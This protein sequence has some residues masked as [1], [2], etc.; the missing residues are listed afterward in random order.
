[1]KNVWPD[2]KPRQKPMAGLFKLFP[3]R[4]DFCY[5][6]TDQVELVCSC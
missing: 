3:E 6:R 1:L 2:S 4:R 5:L